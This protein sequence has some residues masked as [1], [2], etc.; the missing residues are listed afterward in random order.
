MPL[1]IANALSLATALV[2]SCVF[3]SAHAV[4]LERV[5]LG[6]SAPG[7]Q[8]YN[9]QE[10]AAWRVFA[11]S[12][13][14]FKRS[15]IYL[16]RRQASGW[17]EPQPMPFA[18]PRWRDSDPH[19]SPD[20]LRLTFVSDRP[21]EGDAALGQLDLFE[22][23]LGDD[24]RWSAPSRLPEPLQSTSYEL[25][26]ERHGRLLYFTS[27]RPG[28]PARMAIYQAR[29]DEPGAAPQPLPSPI[30]DGS[31]NSDF[32]VSPDGRYAL[33]WS[34]REGTSGSGD[35]YLAERMGEGFGPARRLPEP[36]NGPGLEFTPS[37]SS[38]GQWLYFA[39][40]GDQP[41]GL[42][43]VSRTSWPVLLQAM[44]LPAPQPM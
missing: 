12:E 25:G 38:D 21:A 15:Q 5:E 9:L 4:T 8:A 32:T 43:H 42:S 1:A 2:A 26:P 37:V 16:Q 3:A 40:T 6:D 34:H 10:T 23:R 24:G 22:S 29:P 28:G 7:I 14:G 39:S 11:R 31:H 27:A 36:V 35:L 33:W 18:D 20:G 44:G 30:N 13:A 17:G 19:L 41:E